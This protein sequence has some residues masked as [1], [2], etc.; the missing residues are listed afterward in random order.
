MLIS[1]DEQ[2]KSIDRSVREPAYLQLVNILSD[3]I[4]QGDYLPGSRLPSESE[5]CRRYQ[6]SPM[7][8]RRSI[9]TLLDLGLIT[10][11]KGSGTYVRIPDLKG[12]T[13]GLEEFH[14]VF[15]D[16]KRTKVEVLEAIIIKADKAAARRLEIAEG[17]R[18][19]LI[20]RVLIRDGD[21]IIYHREQL[22]YDPYLPIV[23]AE[24]EVTS[25]HGLFI[26]NGETRL[27][28]GELVIEAAVLNREEA[29]A[30]NTVLY[31]S[32]F[33][34]EHIFYDFEDRPLSWGRFI[35]RGDRL[36]FKT[37][38]GAPKRVPSNK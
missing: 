13:F 11:I 23:E 27:R 26:G 29:N 35:C 18:T 33:C 6:V 12:V 16:K 28:R 32:A 25:L 21:P 37:S 8:V 17:D 31:Q 15:N 9:K 24:L 20:K 22:I 4:S 19:I 10:T 36:R 34:L 14:N 5:L 38:V 2:K 3:Q 7:T 30:L 1:M